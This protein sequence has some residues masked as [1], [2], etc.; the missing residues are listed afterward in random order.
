MEIVLPSAQDYALQNSEQQDDLLKDI[1]E[2][3]LAHHPEA[4]MISG[5]QQGQLLTMISQMIRPK[6]I[7]EIGTFTGYSALCLA[8]GLTEDGMLHTIEKREADAAT[9]NRFFKKSPLVNRITLHVGNALEII[10]SLKESWDLIFVDADK[11]GYKTYYEYL[12]DSVHPNCWLLFDNVFFHGDVLKEN[13]QGKNGRAIHEFNQHLSSDHRVE[14]LM[15]TV[16][17]GLTLVR[18]K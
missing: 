15:L 1:H 6:R 7:L 13:I 9:A 4:H 10:P 2:H 16:R 18:K 8:K 14:K 11:T 17:D 12:I 3:T 5:P